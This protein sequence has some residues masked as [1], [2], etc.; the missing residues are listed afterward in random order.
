MEPAC[1]FSVEYPSLA[2]TVDWVLN[3]EQIKSE[4][5]TIAQF[6]ETTTYNVTCELEYRDNTLIIPEYVVANTQYIATR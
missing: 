3:E 1:S 2:G 6:E 5:A 4:A